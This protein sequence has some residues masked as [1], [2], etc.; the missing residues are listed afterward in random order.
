MCTPDTASITHAPAGVP[1]RSGSRRRRCR[2]TVGQIGPNK[3]PWRHLETAF[4][5]GSSA[6]LATVSTTHV[7]LHLVRRGDP[8]ASPR[9]GWS[10][11]PV[12]TLCGPEERSSNS[13][14]WIAAARAPRHRAASNSV[15]APAATRP[16]QMATSGTPRTCAGLRLRRRAL[17]R[18][19]SIGTAAARNLAAKALGAHALWS[20]P[21]SWP[22][23]TTLVAMT[24]PP[25]TTTATA[26]GRLRSST[27][28]F[29][30]RGSEALCSSS[31][32]K[33]Y[34]W[35]SS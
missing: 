22:R 33:P 23:M 32:A 3:P 10:C 24:A 28:R 29:L 31:W 18:I 5:A 34:S 35:C 16:L 19:P 8:A 25:A 21:T 12:W 9:C 11:R 26:A 2:T 17:S 13:I 1:R 30:V 4:S 20:A 27:I 7:A 14:G 15:S 6:S